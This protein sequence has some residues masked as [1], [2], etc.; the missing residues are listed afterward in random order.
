ML[1]VARTGGRGRGSGVWGGQQR[2]WGRA[3]GAEREQLQGLDQALIEKLVMGINTADPDT[4]QRVGKNGIVMGVAGCI[5]VK[6]RFCNY[7]LFHV[8]NS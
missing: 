4:A 3:E 5:Y 2:E 1:P 8:S 6:Q 7:S